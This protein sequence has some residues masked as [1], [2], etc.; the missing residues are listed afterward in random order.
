MW[1]TGVNTFGPTGLVQAGYA[2]SSDGLN[3]TKYSGN[4]VIPRGLR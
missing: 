4:P 3:W 1:Y 2:T